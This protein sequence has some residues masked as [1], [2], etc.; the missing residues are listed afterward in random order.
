M[1]KP[2]ELNPNCSDKSDNKLIS[3]TAENLEPLRLDLFLA[4]KF[5]D[6]SRSFLKKLIDQNKVK[7]DNKIINRSSFIVKPGNKLEIEFTDTRAVGEFLKLP[8]Q[9]LGIR[10][11]YETP[12]FLI[13]YKPAGI[14]VHIPHTHSTEITLVDW[15]LNYFKDLEDQNSIFSIQKNIQENNSSIN[16]NLSTN[17]NINFNNSLSSNYNQNFYLT[18]NSGDN[19]NSNLSNNASLDYNFRANLS[20][21]FLRP[22]IVHRLDK[23]TSGILVVAKT[24]QA[25]AY[26]SDLFKNR[27]IEKT[28]LAVVS[29]HPEKSGTIKSNIIR[30]QKHKQKMTISEIDGRT[31]RTSWQVLEY[32]K[33]AALLEVKPFT[34]RT[35]QIRVHLESIG[36]PIIGD[37]VYGQKSDLINR[38]ALHAYKLK[39]DFE[40]IAYIFS[41][42][43]PKDMQEL[44]S[45][46]S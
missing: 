28:Y 3:F 13:V 36:H 43:M 4:D 16:A 12:S 45:K 5:K 8:K 7:I 11:L 46:L 18:N 35:H 2:I 23:D 19:L 32:L 41:W 24:P 26:F 44:I 37:I 27:K 33:D 38:Q 30:N 40:N 20:K 42:Y 39:F 21:N 29:G 14:L 15:L 34:G 9:D 6:F 1:N 22:G 17:K 31:A 25:Q 10:V